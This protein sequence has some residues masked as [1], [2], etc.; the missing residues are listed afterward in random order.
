[1]TSGKPYTKAMQELVFEPLEMLHTEHD[2][3]GA[4]KGKEAV[5]YS[6]FAD[7]K[8]IPAITRRD[9]SFLFG[10][11]GYLSTPVDLVNLAQNMRDTDYLSA[12]V[13]KLL[14]TAVKLDNGDDNPQKY[15]LGWRIETRR[16]VQVFGRPVL[17][18]HHGGTVSS[19]AS[20]FLLTYPEYQASIA[21]AT[22][23]IPKSDDS[24][25]DLRSEM[26]ILLGKY[27]TTIR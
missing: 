14:F 2:I 17:G 1:M 26:W 20:A 6:R 12:E 10:G 16:N 8:F 25:E 4:A 5:Y 19:A 3:E 23:T 18:I 11:G 21:F 7:D 22:N 15:A 24:N 13:Q 27:V 9:R